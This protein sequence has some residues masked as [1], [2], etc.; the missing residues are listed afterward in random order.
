MGYSVVH[1]VMSTGYS[2][3]HA[4]ITLLVDVIV[5]HRSC[6]DVPFR[7]VAYNKGTCSPSGPLL[8]GRGIPNESG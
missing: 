3:V 1:A 2:T 5:A 7:G 6:G 8:A 4:V